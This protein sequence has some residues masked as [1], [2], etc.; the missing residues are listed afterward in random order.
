MNE[1]GYETRPFGS[2]REYPLK[3][4]IPLNPEKDT[5]R[6]TV[7][8]AVETSPLHGRKWM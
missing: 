7:R 4:I 3:N 6:A 8:M 1:E 5:T 2:R